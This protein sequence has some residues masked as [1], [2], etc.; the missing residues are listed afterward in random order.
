MEQVLGAHLSPGAQSTSF[1]FSREWHHF[2]VVNMKGNDIS[3]GK[4]LSDYVGSGPPSGTGQSRLLQGMG[5][6]CWAAAGPVYF[7]A[8]P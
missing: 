4:V 2:L 8:S 5:V 7:Q 6:L 3:S 1:S